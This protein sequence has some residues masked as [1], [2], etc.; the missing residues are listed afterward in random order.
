M[1]VPPDLISVLVTVRDGARFVGEAIESLPA[2][3]DPCFEIVII[4][5]GSEDRTA[6][7]VRSFSDNRIRFVSAGRT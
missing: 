7:V 4:D 6:E 2:Q 1:H 5:D 3:S